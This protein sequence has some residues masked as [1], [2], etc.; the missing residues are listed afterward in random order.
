MMEKP[1]KI[2]LGLGRS[3]GAQAPWWMVERIPPEVP[4]VGRLT[5]FGGG[6]VRH[7]RGTTVHLGLGLMQTA[8]GE[9]VRPQAHKM[10]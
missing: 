8:S 4:R 3:G 2:L 5:R 9:C 1:R 6:T 7:W 10:P